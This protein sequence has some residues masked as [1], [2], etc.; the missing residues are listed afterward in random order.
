M[1]RVTL[2]GRLTRDPELK[3]TSNGNSVCTF[4]LAVQR[5]KG[6]GDRTADFIRCVAWG[7]T[8]DV[9]GKYLIK[10]SHIGVTGSIETRT[11]ERDNRKEYITE[12]RLDNYG[13]LE[14]LQ[15]KGGDAGGADSGAMSAAA[16]AYG[17]E[18][19][20]QNG[21]HPDASGFTPVSVDDELPF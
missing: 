18:A 1:N 17:V 20:A 6:S 7:K 14:F 4:T 9:A 16:A 12:V 3:V 21:D 10:G 15:P 8:A 2:T 19:E 13:G 11:F 5:P